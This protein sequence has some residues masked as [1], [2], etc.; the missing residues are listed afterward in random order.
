MRIPFRQGVFIF[1]QDSS[2]T[3]IHIRKNPD[4]LYLD[5][6]ISPKS[7]YILMLRFLRNQL[8]DQYV[9]ARQTIYFQKLFLFREL[10]VHLP[11]IRLSIFIGI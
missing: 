11:Q 3:P 7:R 5:V 2:L 10:G 4:A 9:M 8:S 6:A 1:Q